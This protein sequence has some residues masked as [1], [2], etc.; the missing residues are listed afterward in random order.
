MVPDGS[1]LAAHSET[2]VTSDSNTIRATEIDPSEDH[3]AQ[4]AKQRK[5]DGIGSRVSIDL[6]LL[7]YPAGQTE[8][9]GSATASRFQLLIF[10]TLPNPNIR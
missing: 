7:N 8:L 6:F 4:P 10:Q 9:L 1:R 2:C 5:G 3:A